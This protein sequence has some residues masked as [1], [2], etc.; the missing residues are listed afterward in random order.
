MALLAMNWKNGKPPLDFV[1]FSI[2]YK[3]P[4]GEKFFPLR[5]RISFP[6]ANKNDKNVRYTLR[7]PLQIFRWVHFPR[8]AELA[9]LFTYKVMPVFMNKA[10]ELSYGEAQEC[11]IALARETYPK[12]LNVTF[13]R[14]FVS[15]QAF[16]DRYEK[17]G[18]IK[19]LLPPKST[20]GLRFKPTHPKTAEAL[21]WM[22]FEI[23]IWVLLAVLIGIKADFS[24]P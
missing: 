13:T 22:G 3:E 5:N 23:S 20:E 17:E 16:V 1:G 9:G 12:A 18:P 15:S 2:E 19:T 4:K 10:G 7:S 24:I 6:G 8:N 21:A 11:S 14:G